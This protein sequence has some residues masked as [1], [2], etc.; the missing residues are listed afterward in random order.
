MTAAVDEIAPDVFRISS[1][2]E[3]YD[4]TFN[5]F[6][7]RD[8][9]PLL[10]HTGMPAMFPVVRDAVRGLIDP[11]RL[12]W[13]SFSH[14]EPDECGALNE[15]LAAAPSAQAACGLVGALVCVNHVAPRPARVLEDGEVLVTGRRRFRYLRTPHV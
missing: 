7:V 5:Q 6:L 14:F 12:R 11:A 15:W 2:L 9:E 4:L 8:D 10:F 1:Y 3:S 13:V